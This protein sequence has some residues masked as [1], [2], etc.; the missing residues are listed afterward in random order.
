MDRAIVIALIALAGTLIGAISA[1]I[2]ALVQ[3]TP[4]AAN[5][6]TETP[7]FIYTLISADTPNIPATNPILPTPTSIP[8]HNPITDTPIASPT[9]TSIA[10]ATVIAQPPTQTLEST[11]AISTPDCIFGNLINIHCSSISP[12]Y[13]DNQSISTPTRIGNNVAVTF[14]NTSNGSGIAF[15]FNAPLDVSGFTYVELNGT[16]TQD[17][18]FQLEYK[19]GEGDP[20]PIVQTSSTNV[21][22]TTQNTL[23]IQI[24]IE[25]GGLIDQLAINCFQVGESSKF[26]IESIQLKQ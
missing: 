25:Y 14:T 2:I 20:I 8:A 3:S 5:S 11:V 6:P 23:K 9:T 1:V 17:F 7:P 16:S 21:F 13:V 4:P 19:A 15:I 24:S 18:T 22:P 12:I 10:S 26:V